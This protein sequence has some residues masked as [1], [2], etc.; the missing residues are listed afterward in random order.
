MSLRFGL[1]IRTTVAHMT[2]GAVLSASLAIAV[3]LLL[4][5][6][7]DR[8]LQATMLESLD[9]LVQIGRLQEQPEL[10]ATESLKA[11]V[12]T[13][14]GDTTL[15][16][17]LLG[18]GPG[19]HDL[20][21]SEEEL[22]VAV[23][24]DGSRRYVLTYDE[25]PIARLETWFMLGGLI[26]GIVGFTFTALWLGSWMSGR[27]LKPVISLARQIN[28]IGDEVSRPLLRGP[29]G[30]DEIGDLARAFEHYA[31]RI[32]QFVERER[33]F[34]S[35]V[36]HELRNPIM[37]ASSALEL[38]LDEPDLA[39]MTRER[40]QRLARALDRMGETVDVFLALGR[41]SRPAYPEVG[42]MEV[43]IESIVRAVIDRY[44]HVARDKELD[45][46]LETSASSWTLGSASAVSVVLENIIGNAV[47]HTS[48]GKIDVKIRS[49]GVTVTDTGPGIP[50]DEYSRI[51][52]RGF[53]GSNASP[54]GSGLGLSIVSRICDH[55]GWRVTMEPAHP[56]G[57]MVHLHL[58]TA[59]GKT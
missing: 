50:K 21:T 49:S 3:A 43:D 39:P 5:Y 36:S 55:W 52:E 16:E 6:M 24:D 44:L 47:R 45:V 28:A 4:E 29:W 31:E 18:L 26:L 23:R 59:G 42:L 1:R 57:T 25:T 53:R 48:S 15:P 32:G 37:S 51:F 22:L 54:H 7:E 27:I 9:L 12:L 58:S 56:C 11:Y 17:P 33:A 2:L 34:T 19:I 8:Y 46:R 10:P 20:D 40:L 13:Q 41:E 30:D 14:D 35:D 38:L